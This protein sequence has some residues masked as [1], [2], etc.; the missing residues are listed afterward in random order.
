VIIHK[1]LLPLTRRVELLLPRNAVVLCVQVQHN[2]PTIWY[3]FSEGDIDQELEVVIFEI[4]TTGALFF[5]TLEYL[6]TFQIDNGRFV[7]HVFYE[8][9]GVK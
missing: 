1:E 6:G 2:I 4:Q 5:T 8:K 3:S 9:K 7:G